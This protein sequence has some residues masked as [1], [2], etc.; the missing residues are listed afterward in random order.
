MNQRIVIPIVGLLF[1][2]ITLLFAIGGSA[3]SQTN[4]N[5]VFLNHADSLVGTEID[6][7]KARL[8][9]GNVK[10][11]QGKIIITCQKAVQYLKSNKVTM[12]GVVEVRDDSMRMVAQRGLYDANTK[13]VEG[14]E[15]VRLEDRTTTL[16]ALYG[17]YF[18]EEKRAY[19]SGNV[20]VQD[21]ASTLTCD[22]LTYYRESQNLIADRNVVIINPENNLMLMC[23]HFENDKKAGMSLM[24]NRPMALQVETSSDGTIDTLIVTSRMMESFQDSTQRLIATDSVTLTRNGL[25]AEGGIAIFMMKLDSINLQRTPIMWYSGAGSETTQVVG[26]SMFVKLIQRKLNKLYVRGNAFAVSQAD[27]IDRRRYNQLTGEE[28][29]IKFSGNAIS[30][31]DVDKTATM[32]YYVY[33]GGLPDGLNKT[34][35]DH[36]T[37]SFIDKK[38]DQIKVAGGIEGQYVPERLIRGREFE[39]NLPGFKWRSRRYQRSIGSNREHVNAGTNGK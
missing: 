15:R 8:L 30:A 13:I 25:A 33:D 7:E 2:L 34:S 37:M 18:S 35:G 28:L 9:I 6:G 31:I 36:V 27:S 26:D 22:E 29:V 10:F 39:Y 14:F 4:E 19:F 5:V 32:V 20:S 11:T 21:T 16:N 17:K 12:E 1:S 3:H 23:G 38:I 24:T